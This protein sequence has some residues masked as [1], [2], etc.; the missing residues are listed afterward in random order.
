MKQRG[1][2][3]GA[4][5]GGTTQR[6]KENR[7]G[8]AATRAAEAGMKLRNEITGEEVEV[9]KA[10]CAQA[11]GCSGEKERWAR[12]IRENGTKKA[13]AWRGNSAADRFVKPRRGKKVGEPS[14][15][16]ARCFLGRVSSFQPRAFSSDVFSHA[17]LRLISISTRRCLSVRSFVRS[18]NEKKKGTSSIFE[19]HRLQQQPSLPTLSFDELLVWRRWIR[20]P[21]RKGR[22]ERNRARHFCHGAWKAS[23]LP[24]R[25]TMAVIL[26]S[27]FSIYPSENWTS[28]G[29]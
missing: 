12:E 20:Q 29:Q 7:V 28:A 15:L 13:G 27:R 3:I 8:G 26:I 22:S 17:R 24:A 6:R 9:G 11:V 19:M 16:L 21:G 25:T 23:S 1:C 10:G 18:A 14:I 5:E 2:V 4:S